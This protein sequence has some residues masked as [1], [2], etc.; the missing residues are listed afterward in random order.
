MSTLDFVNIAS[1]L[2][3]MAEKQ[4]HELAIIVPRCRDRDGGPTYTH[5]TFEQLNK[6]SDCIARGLEA[7][8]IGRGVRTALMVGPSLEFFALTFAISKAGAVPVVIDPGIGIKNLKKCLA[9]A[10]PE[11]FIGIPKAHVAR[12]LF[13]WGKKTIRTTVTVGRRLFWGGL[14]LEQVKKKGQSNT[15]YEMARTEG[16]EMAAVLFTSGGTGTPKGA[17]YTHANFAA[18]VEIIR[19]TYGI[20]PGEIDLATFPLFA[21]FDPALGMTTVVPDMDPTRPAHVDPEKIIEAIKDF[22]I[23]NMFG[24]PALINRVGRYG[25]ENGVKL[26]TLR[27]IIAAGAPM[28]PAVLERFC[29]MLSP[30]TQVFTGFGATESMPVCSIGSHEILGETRHG[31]DEGKGVCVGR[32]VEDMTVSVIKITDTPI[33]EWD[34]A[35]KLATN[36]IGEITVKGPVVTSAYYKKEEATGLA[37]IYEPDGKGLWHRMGD[38]GFFDQKGRLWFC[39]RK[40]Q[41]VITE[42]GTLFTIP[43]EGVF[44][45]HP[46]VYR[47][48]LA[49]VNVHGTIQPVLC[50]ELEEGSKDVDKEKV[51]QEL[52]ELGASKPHTKDIRTILFHD[53]FPV[54]I[55]HNAKIFRDKLGVWAQ[56]N[57]TG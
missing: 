21:L 6:E 14:S 9:Q 44:N 27:R 28:P 35:L 43:C 32:P 48:A 17:I 18:Q 33:P 46:D 15:P 54:D 20:V 1:F 31:T 52:L 7:I 29:T 11:A 16:H 42:S 36:E 34:D 41:R 39:G 49:G 13:G 30:D 51:K 8:G 25:A 2:P 47:T 57:L 10:E 37:K 56:K 3:V 26:P 55:R 38:L 53:S 23:T 4:P 12:I 19:K 45:T 50:V 40:S 5:Y 24:S 22:D